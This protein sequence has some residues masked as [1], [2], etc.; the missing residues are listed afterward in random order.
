M[1]TSSKAP[2]KSKVYTDCVQLRPETASDREFLYQLYASTRLPEMAM[3]GWDKGQIE[4]FLRMQF[5]LQHGQ[6][7]QNH[8]TASFDII[9]I[10]DTPAGRLYV[11]RSDREIL[12]IDISLMPG[13]KGRGA[14]GRILRDLVEEADARGLAM[15]LHVEVNNPIRSFYTRLGFREMEQRGMYYSMMRKPLQGGKDA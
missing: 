9:C 6:Y 15:G 1:P 10:N 8:A 12:I 4:S 7:Q 11:H 14:G 2:R 3:T 13:F 5:D